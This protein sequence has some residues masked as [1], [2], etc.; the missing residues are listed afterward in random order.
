MRGLE[1]NYFIANFFLKKKSEVVAIKLQI[2][3][4]NFCYTNNANP[5]IMS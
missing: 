4:Y 3:K 2:S 5:Q 1:N